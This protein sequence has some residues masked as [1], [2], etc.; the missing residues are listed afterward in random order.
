MEKRFKN[1][2]KPE[3]DEDGNAFITR[4]NQYDIKEYGWKCI[5]PENLEIGKNV[6]VGAFTLILAHYGIELCDEVQIG[7]FCFIDSWSTIDDKSGKVRIG[8]GT[9]IG[10]HSTVMPGITIGEN[11]IIGAYSFVNK[12]IPDN[13]L[14]YGIP[15]KI[16]K[17]L[18]G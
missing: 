6:D 15:C 17:T 1:W 10:A 11:S 8:K 16:K 13:V 12:N 9:V 14:A 18:K 7:P 2:K 5:H 3:F 4:G